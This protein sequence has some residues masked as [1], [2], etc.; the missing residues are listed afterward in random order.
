MTSV[1]EGVP[2]LVYEALAMGLP[3][4]PRRCRATSS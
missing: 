4:S 3:W 2:Y 1:F